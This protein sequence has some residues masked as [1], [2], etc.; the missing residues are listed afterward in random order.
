M[1]NLL[2]SDERDK[3]ERL[4]DKKMLD[5][6]KI[7]SLFYSYGRKRWKSPD[8]FAESLKDIIDELNLAKFFKIK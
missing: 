3:I 6:F 4:A 1:R 8:E 7:A 2:S 5:A